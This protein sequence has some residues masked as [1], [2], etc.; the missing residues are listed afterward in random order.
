M[1]LYRARAIMASVRKTRRMKGEEGGVHGDI[2][3]TRDWD[4]MR[5]S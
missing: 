1:A 4:A 5:A 2:L 3:W